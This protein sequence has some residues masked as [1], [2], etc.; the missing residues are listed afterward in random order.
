MMELTNGEAGKAQH[1]VLDADARMVTEGTTDDDEAPIQS[2]GLAIKVIKTIDPAL[3]EWN[4]PILLAS[5]I[6]TIVTGVTLFLMIWKITDCTETTIIGRATDQETWRTLNP[7]RCVL[8]N[9]YFFGTDQTDPPIANLGDTL[10]VTAPIGN[11][12]F[13]D[14]KP[15]FPTLLE[16]VDTP[17]CTQDEKLS[18]RALS[19]IIDNPKFKYKEAYDHYT[20]EWLEDWM[21]S[22]Q[23]P[24]DVELIYSTSYLVCVDPL[25]AIGAAFGFAGPVKIVATVLVVAILSMCGYIQKEGGKK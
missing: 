25:I 18:M 20:Q 19:E 9:S 8:Y 6:M 14:G 16:G 23:C 11:A 4:R 24:E 17:F 22:I 15:G 12:C 21:S 2:E 13:F 10:V 7:H 5:V 3:L 1:Q